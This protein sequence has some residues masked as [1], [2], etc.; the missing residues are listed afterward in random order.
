MRVT[1]RLAEDRLDL[2]R[3]I[4][5]SRILEVSPP[6]YGSRTVVVGYPDV[7]SV[8]QLLQ[9]GDH[10]EVLAPD[11]ARRRTGELAADVAARHSS[12]KE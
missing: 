1:A 5:G 3:R 8:R 12:P 6:E 2:A 4:L 7:E 11:A 10:I 9:F